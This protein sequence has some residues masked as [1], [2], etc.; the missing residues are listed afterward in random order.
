MNSFLF[1]I[2]SNDGKFFEENVE[3]V[4]FTSI[5]KGDRAIL[6]N[7]EDLGCLLDVSKIFYKKND[8]IYYIS[9]SGGI[10]SF[11]DNS[12]IFIVDTFELENEIDKNRVL[13][14]KSDAEN[15]L[16]DSAK[17]PDELKKA[18]FSLKKALNRLSILK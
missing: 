13:K 3:E 16:K 7:S 8:N 11:H 5:L 10:M 2:T 9:I 18:E 17:S 6:S 12:A 4:Y 14:A 15:I 1:S